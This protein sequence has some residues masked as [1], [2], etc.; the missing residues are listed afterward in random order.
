MC[1]FNNISCNYLVKNC[2]NIFV[3]T[4]TSESCEPA[5]R[6]SD[7]V[8][9]TNIFLAKYKSVST[10]EDEKQTAVSSPGIACVIL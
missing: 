2:R 4:F 6:I 3:V 8:Q 9:A 1:S 10:S 5:E 7:D